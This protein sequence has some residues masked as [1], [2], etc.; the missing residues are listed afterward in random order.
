MKPIQLIAFIFTLSLFS[1]NVIAQNNQLD[2]A[3]SHADEAFKARDSKELAV[4]AEIAQPFA[5]AA[6]KEMH[7]SHEGRNHIEAG[8]VSLGQ[9]VEKGKLGATDSARPA[10]GEALRHFKEAKE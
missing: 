2:K 6:Q 7:F 5:L 1:I 8:I 10:A 4:Y 9:A 3:I